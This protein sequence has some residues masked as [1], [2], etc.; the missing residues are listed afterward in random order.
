MDT[1]FSIL[2]A[3]QG[4]AAILDENGEILAC[5]E[6]WKDKKN[7][8]I[9]LDTDPDGNNYFDHCRYAVEIGNDYA[10]RLI[11]GIRE[12]IEQKKKSFNLTISSEN[13]HEKW[14]KAEVSK[15]HN[16]TGNCVLLVFTDISE[17]LKTNQALRESEAAYRHYFQHFVIK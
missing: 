7:F 5:N 16:T 4:A 9:W 13:L 1:E 8:S 3:I 10:L 11:F 15:I 2:N 14:Y 6:H 12:V 17:I